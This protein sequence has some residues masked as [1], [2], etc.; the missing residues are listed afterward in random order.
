MYISQASPKDTQ[1]CQ[2]VKENLN[3]RYDT[4]LQYDIAAEN[5][6]W[7]F[8]IL[9]FLVELES[10]FKKNKALLPTK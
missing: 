8:V 6:W 1:R 5:F 7:N 9:S 10:D 4:V 3:L 2:L